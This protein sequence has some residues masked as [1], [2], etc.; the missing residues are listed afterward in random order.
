TRHVWDLDAYATRAR[1]FGCHTIEV[2]GHDVEA[3]D[4]AYAEAID[5]AGQPVVIVGKPVTGKAY[6]DVEDKSGFHGKSLDHSEEVIATLGGVR[7]R[8]IDVAKPETGAS[9]H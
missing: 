7:N 4:R 6:P 5:T 9:K 2:D 1:A 3:I 8:K